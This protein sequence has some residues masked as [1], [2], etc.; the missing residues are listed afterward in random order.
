MSDTDQ[1]YNERNRLVALLASIFPA[2]T[3]RTEIEGWDPEWHGCV[4]IDLPNGQASWHYHDREA[5]LFAH[6]PP[7]AG[8]WDGHTT[9][10]KYERIAELTKGRVTRPVEWLTPMHY[11]KWSDEP[12]DVRHAKLGINY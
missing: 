6:L 5:H 12:Q 2:G 4:Y 9:E 8:E 1:A 3:K 10:Q 11:D 7:Y